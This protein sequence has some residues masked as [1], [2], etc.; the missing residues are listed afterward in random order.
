MNKEKK[1]HPNVG[2]TAHIETPQGILVEVEVLEYIPSYGRDRW[3]VKPISGEKEAIVEK[4]E[5]KKK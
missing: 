3:K 2:K 4:L 5:F 1:S